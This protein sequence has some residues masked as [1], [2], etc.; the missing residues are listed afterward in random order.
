MRLGALRGSSPSKRS[1]F[2]TLRL[3]FAYVIV[4]MQINI[5]EELF[6]SSPLALDG[7]KLYPGQN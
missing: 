6:E 1:R 5:T 3:L 2:A 4:L 7:G